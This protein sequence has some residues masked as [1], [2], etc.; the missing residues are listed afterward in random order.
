MPSFLVDG[1]T[2]KGYIAASEELDH[3][4]LRFSYRP[5]TVEE[6]GPIIDASAKESNFY[7]REATKRV[8]SKI[9]DWSLT[10]PAGNAV[11][12]SQANLMRLHPALLGRLVAVVIG[13]AG[14]DPDPQATPKERTEMIVEGQ[15]RE[16][17]D[18]KN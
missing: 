8:A 4:E 13:T 15:R 11:L 6:R 18:L 1:Y 17:S 10:D 5:M 7:Y 14:S 2:A 16:V 9:L 3:D 12:C